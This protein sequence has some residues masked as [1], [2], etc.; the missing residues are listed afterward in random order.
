MRLD[1]RGKL[2]QKMMQ[3]TLRIAYLALTIFAVFSYFY[4]VF[5]PSIDAVGLAK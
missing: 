4:S 2:D 1:Q 3:F 5:A